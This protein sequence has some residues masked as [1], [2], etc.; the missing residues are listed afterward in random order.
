MIQPLAGRHHVTRG[1]RKDLDFSFATIQLTFNSLSSVL[2][3]GLQG[4][5]STVPGRS[6]IIQ[7][8]ATFTN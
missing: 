7:I 2:P 5:F 1:S 6:N 8:L 4:E 3:A